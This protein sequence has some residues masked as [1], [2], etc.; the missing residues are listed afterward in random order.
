MKSIYGFA[1]AVLLAA[2]IAGAGW[3]ASQ[4]GPTEYTYTYADNGQTAVAPA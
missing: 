4:T 1:A 3:T 2:C